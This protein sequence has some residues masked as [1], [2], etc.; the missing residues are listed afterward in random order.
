M[1]AYVNGSQQKRLVT[2][3]QISMEKG[4]SVDG[5]GGGKCSLLVALAEIYGEDSANSV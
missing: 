3:Q 2:M 5:P 4:S 1:V